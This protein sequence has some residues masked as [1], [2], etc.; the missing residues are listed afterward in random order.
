MIKEPGKT[1]QREFAVSCTSF[2][3]SSS[4]DGT[5]DPTDLSN[6]ALPAYVLLDSG[7]EASQLPPDLFAALQQSLQAKAGP[8][9]EYYAPCDLATSTASFSF[10]F[11]GPT[12]ATIVTPAG[13]FIKANIPATP[14]E[15]GPSHCCA[16]SVS[17]SPDGFIL[18]DDFLHSAYLVFDVDNEV[19][20]LAQANLSPSTEKNV[21]E[22]R[23]GLH[24][25]PGAVYSSAGNSSDNS[26]AIGT[27]SGAVASATD[28]FRGNGTATGTQ[29]PIAGIT[30]A[31]DRVR[32]SGMEGLMLGI[33][34][35]FCA[36][37]W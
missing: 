34:V 19:I 1:T 3:A 6:N 20:A 10:G 13:A 21:H 25:I 26:T 31:A 16:L 32:G 29:P 15:C 37:M 7:G 11:G 24:G 12:G 5:A 8:D 30:G 23:S 36:L 2:T 22:I 27:A 33:V 14:E 18:G 4:S 28:G 17:P 9:G 35:G